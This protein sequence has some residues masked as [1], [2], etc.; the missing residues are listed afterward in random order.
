MILVGL[1]AAVAA[2]AREPLPDS[3]VVQGTLVVLP[4]ILLPQGATGEAFDYR[5]FEYSTRIENS[6]ET[7]GGT[8][9]AFVRTSR[10]ARVY[11]GPQLTEVSEK[12]VPLSE[13]TAER[14]S[15]D[16]S[17][18]YFRLSDTKRLITVPRAPWPPGEDRLIP[19]ASPK[20][21]FEG[22]GDDTVVRRELEGMPPL[23]FSLRAA[24][25]GAPRAH[26]DALEAKLDAPVSVEFE[27]E[28][29]SR[30]CTFIEKYLD[31]SIAIDPAAVGPVFGH[32]G[33]LPTSS[34]PV[35]D[36]I[37]QY[38]KL[39]N[40]PLREALRAMCRPL[41]LGYELRPG[42][43]W[44]TARD[45]IESQENRKARSADV[46]SATLAIDF[47]RTAVVGHATVNEAPYLNIGKPVI[48]TWQGHLT[49]GIP[50]DRWVLVALDQVDPGIGGGLEYV[51][52]IRVHATHTEDV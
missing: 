1:L 6:D 39:R 23:G 41:E 15:A 11:S 49:L 31:M 40:V 30:I 28:H 14:G 37:V 47:A 4:G 9:V 27:H 21:Y 20:V 29:I 36:G 13:S 32:A 26:Q 5:P 35:T 50:I 3:Y 10:F 12:N 22:I 45:K 52:L 18:I 24:L 44:I 7:T 16:S 25:E 34:C 48:Q 51:L 19:Q 2:A 38:V 46:E 43:I 17:G 8:A 42:Y 33:I